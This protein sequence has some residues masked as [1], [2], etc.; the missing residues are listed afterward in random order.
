MFKNKVPSWLP[1]SWIFYILTAWDVDSLMRN[2]NFPHCA[3]LYLCVPVSYTEA[4]CATVICC[5]ANKVSCWKQFPR[6]K[7]QCCQFFGVPSLRNACVPNN[8]V[9]S[10]VAACLHPI[11]CK[12][13]G[14][15]RY[16]LNCVPSLVQNE[17]LL[18]EATLV[19]EQET[20]S[21]VWQRQG[22][23]E[24]GQTNERRQ[25]TKR[26]IKRLIRLNCVSG[27]HLCKRQWFISR[28]EQGGWQ[29]LTHEGA[30]AQL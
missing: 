6:T 2:S 21:C 15:A 9:L 20:K 17:P 8:V 22:A 28:L 11:C 30:V 26:I 25:K 29:E 3:L 7:P 12:E 10:D 27:Y 24:E 5:I 4:H 19:A 18:T 1:L 23:N 16:V 13:E 14:H